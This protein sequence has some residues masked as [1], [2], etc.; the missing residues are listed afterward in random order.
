MDLVMR[1][2]EMP[3]NNIP[4]QNTVIPV[5][6]GISFLVDVEVML[7]LCVLYNSILCHIAV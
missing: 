2:I 1:G 3:D 7:L 4:S 6:C 5:S